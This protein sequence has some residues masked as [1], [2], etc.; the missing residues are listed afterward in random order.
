M[1][2][3]KGALQNVYA[4]DEINGAAD[5]ASYDN[6]KSV[7]GENAQVDGIAE[8]TDI[9]DP[10][11]GEEEGVEEQGAQAEDP[12]M[13]LLGENVDSKLSGQSEETDEEEPGEE[14]LEELPLVDK[15]QLE[16]QAEEILNRMINSHQILNRKIDSI[17]SDS[18]LINTIKRINRTTDVEIES[19]K[20][21]RESIQTQHLYQTRG[22]GARWNPTFSLGVLRTSLI[23]PS[24]SSGT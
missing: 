14:N 12:S 24:S 3:L 16:E 11:N 20:T 7:D 8:T 4:K 2:S 13:E 23:R 1:F 21:T 5:D 19:S 18:E 10:Y 9:D 6:G 17:N 22:L 15:E